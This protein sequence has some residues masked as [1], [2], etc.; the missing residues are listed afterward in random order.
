MN[1][2]HIR[3]HTVD[4]LFTISLFCVFAASALLLVLTGVRVYRSTAQ[5]LEGTYSA[6]TALAYV[7][8]KVRQ[9]DAEGRVSLTEIDG[10]T[11][12]MLTDQAG[13]DIYETYIYSDGD[14]VCELLVRQ[15]TTLSSDMGQQI[16]RVDDFS[17]TDRGDGFLELTALDDYGQ[18][19]SFLLHLRN[20]GGFS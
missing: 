11:A 14:Y 10:L 1:R 2:R 9:H 16:L 7:T 17:I 15:G 13:D 5:R 8:E 20:S 12:I 18:S 6:R 3:P 19:Y 4:L